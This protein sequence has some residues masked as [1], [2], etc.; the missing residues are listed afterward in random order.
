MLGNGWLKRCEADR[1]IAREEESAEVISVL[2]DGRA[3]LWQRSSDRSSHRVSTLK[4]GEVFDLSGL[5]SGRKRSSSVV[6]M[7]RCQVATIS[8]SDVNTIARYHPRIAFHLYQNLSRT[9]PAMAPMSCRRS[10]R[11][12]GLGCPKI[13]HEIEDSLGVS[14]K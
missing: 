1:F 14:D 11:F 13:F 3:E 12:W 7:T 10:S 2:L 6:A 8:W 4:P 5:L 9:L